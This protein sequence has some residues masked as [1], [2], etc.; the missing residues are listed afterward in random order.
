MLMRYQP[1]GD[2][3][4]DPVDRRVVG[5]AAMGRW[6]PA[7]RPPEKGCGDE[8][9][10]VATRNKLG[11]DIQRCRVGPAVVRGSGLGWTGWRVGIGAAA[12]SSVTSALTGSSWQ[13]PASAAMANVASGYLGWLASTGVQAGQAASQA[14]IAAAAFEATVAATV[15]PVAV[16]A[17]RTQ[18][19]SLVTSNLLGFNAP[20]IATVEAEYEQMWAQDVAAMFGYHTGASAAVAALTPFTQVLQSP[21][22]AAA[23]AVQTA[24]IDFPGRTNI[25]NAGLGNLGVGNVGFAS[26]GDG[27]VGGG[28]LGDGNVG[29]GNVGGLNFGSG[30]WGG[31]NLGSGNIGSYNFGPGNL[32]SYN[33]GFG[34]AG[35]YNVGFGN[36]GLGNIGFG[37]SGSNNLGIGLTGSGQVGF[38]GWNSGSG[39]LGLFNSGAGTGRRRC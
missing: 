34:N 6:P 26:V 2:D 36:S 35:D 10:G 21:A 27:N 20:A 24:I 25:F 13:G 19:V 17:N 12:F 4:V 38:G 18:L 33:I 29:F 1:M 15:H 39:N 5:G 7:W 32:G 37:N 14:R 30:N 22:A 16:L 3:R 9:F 11:S 23:G 8:F 28:N 31:F